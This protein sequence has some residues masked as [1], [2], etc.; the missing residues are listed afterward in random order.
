MR[1]YIP[2]IIFILLLTLA[3]SAYFVTQD[4]KFPQNVQLSGL[5][6]QEPAGAPHL[7][8]SG[9]RPTEH[10]VFNN[11]DTIPFALTVSGKTYSLNV[12]PQSTLYDAMLELSQ[13]KE[14][15]FSAT[16]HSG[17]GYFIDE[18]KGT[19]NGNNKYWFFYVNGESSTVGVSTYVPKAGDVIEWKFKESY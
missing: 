3:G 13:R 10:S 16:Y 1:R 6:T 19:K 4:E 11:P 12:D 2:L 7:P 15:T 5:N 14:L 9:T 18:I 17:I 8:Q